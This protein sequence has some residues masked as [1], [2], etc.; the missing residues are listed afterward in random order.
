MKIIHR[1]ILR[2]LFYYFF[3]IFFL[4]SVI[5]VAYQIYDTRDEI[6]AENAAI[7]DVVKY[8]F[9]V[10]PAEMVQVMPLIAMFAVL[11]S[12]GMLAKNKEVLAMVAMGVNFN[13]LAVPVA[14]FGLVVGVGGY[15]LAAQWAPASRYHAQFLYE[16]RIKGENQYSFTGNDELFRKGEGQR[17]YIM[18]NFDRE[19]NIMTGPTILVKNDDG[20][21]LRERLEA[22][23]ARH[24]ESPG[25]GGEI[26]E[27]ENL[28]KWTFKPDGSFDFV[29]YPGPHRIE[30]EEKLGSFLGREKEPDEMTLSELGDY[31]VVLERQGGGPRLP[32][33]LTAYHHI[34]TVPITC[35]LLGL[36]GFTTAVDL[37]T[38]NFVL[39]FSIGLAFGLGFYILQTALDGMGGR[40]LLPAVWAVWAPCALFAAITLALLRRLQY[41]H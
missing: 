28:K 35:L 13:T 26:W 25:G 20:S 3:V 39:A 31:T 19:T 18:A 32:V 17:F 40:G 10:I 7:V 11:F 24:V 30:L 29:R 22:T 34:F 1:Y 2:E 15:F 41:V 38:R 9:L 37:K 27:F 14:I 36:I 23:R 8:I 21:G 5:F 33:Y 6:L 16:V 4:F 12:M